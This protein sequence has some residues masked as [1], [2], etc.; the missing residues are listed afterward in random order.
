MNKSKVYCCGYVVHSKGKQCVPLSTEL[1]WRLV[2][3]SAQRVRPRRLSA[4]PFWEQQ[5]E[6]QNNSMLLS[7]QNRLIPH[8]VLISFLFCIIIT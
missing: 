3:P 4:F 2:S 6:M 1:S 5:P 7:T 8:R